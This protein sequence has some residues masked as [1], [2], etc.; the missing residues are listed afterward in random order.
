MRRSTAIL[1]SPRPANAPRCSSTVSS[2]PTRRLSSSSACMIEKHAGGRPCGRDRLPRPVAFRRPRRARERQSEVPGAPRADGSTGRSARC[3]PR[4]VAPRGLGVGQTA[5]L[6]IRGPATA[7]GWARPAAL[8]P[9]ATDLA[10]RVLDLYAHRDPRSA[11]RLSARAGRPRRSHRRARGPANE[12]VPVQGGAVEQMRTAAAGAA[13]LLAA[14]DGPR[15]PRSPSMVSTPIRMRARRKASS[16]SA[17][18]GSTPHSTLLRRPRRR[19]EG[20]GRD[21]GHRVRPHGPRQRHPRH[22]P[23]HGDGRA[24]CRR[25]ARWRQGRSP[26]G[27]ASRPSASIRPATSL[28]RRT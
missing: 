8:L 2:P 22:R 12:E 4:T 24:A 7:L 17:C 1:P 13:R 6:V 9:P 16:L 11:S 28:Q 27:R 15:S 14:S 19:L 10:Q 23:R 5:P 3:P 26:T 25:R 20:Y 21:R 18:R